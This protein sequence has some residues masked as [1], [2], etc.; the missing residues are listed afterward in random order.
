M[1]VSNNT[2]GI[3]TLLLT[4]VLLFSSTQAWAYVGPGAGIG[5]IAAFV[6][7][8]LF[9]VVAVFGFLWYPIKRMRQK[10]RKG[11]KPKAE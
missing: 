5:A 8:L 4:L 9:L 11:S 1:R 10:G 7:V 2:K 3:G 6:G